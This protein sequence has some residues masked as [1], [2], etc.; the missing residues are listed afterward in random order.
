MWKLSPVTSLVQFLNLNKLI[1]TFVVSGQGRTTL[2]RG[3]TRPLFYLVCP[4]TSSFFPQFSHLQMEKLRYKDFNDLHRPELV[5]LAWKRDLS[6]SK[7][8]VALRPGDVIKTQP[9]GGNSSL[10]LWPPCCLTWTVRREPQLR[11][12]LQQIG[13]CRVCGAF[14]WLLINTGRPSPLW[15]MASLSRWAGL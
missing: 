7:Y 14:Y 3:T 4:I 6:A 11:T 13:L 15:V 1:K 8:E 10:G 9:P 2:G 5:I 12:D